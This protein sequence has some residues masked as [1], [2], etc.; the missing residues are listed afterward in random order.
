MLQCGPIVYLIAD[1]PL[2]KPIIRNKYVFNAFLKEGRVEM[3]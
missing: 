1:L 3:R 2:K